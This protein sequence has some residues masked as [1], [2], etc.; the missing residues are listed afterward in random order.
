MY[1]NLDNSISLDPS[2][3]KLIEKLLLIEDCLSKNSVLH[4]FQR[5]KKREILGLYIWGGAGT[6]KTILSKAWYDSLTISKKY[7]HYQHFMM[8]IH[9]ILHYYNKQMNAAELAIEVAKNISQESKIIFIDEFEIQDITDAHL[10]YNIFQSLINSGVFIVLTTNYQPR[11]I[12]W[13]GIHRDR[14]NSLINFINTSFEIYNLDSDCDYRNNFISNIDRIMHM[15]DIKTKLAAILNNLNIQRLGPLRLD[16]LGRGV[17]L[18]TAQDKLLLTSFDEMFI[19]KLGYSDFV[20]IGQYFDI[21]I[22]RSVRKIANEETD[23]IVRFISFIDNLYLNKVLLF[24]FFYQD[25]SAIYE[26]SKR[27]QGWDRALSRISEMASVDYL[28][29]SKYW[30]YVNSE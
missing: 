29:K 22:L 11:N 12:Y 17:I 7:I 13:G 23:V 24:L 28:N 25:M 3:E 26:G 5:K 2:Q 30:Y 19:N 18:R 27:I 10:I 20:A 21:V 4:F 1:A 14:V 6:G 8:D 16:V 15:D 9:K